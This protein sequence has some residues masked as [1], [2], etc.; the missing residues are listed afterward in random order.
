[1]AKT[2]VFEG[3]PACLGDTG[4][5]QLPMTI[6]QKEFMTGVLQGGAIGAGVATVIDMLIPRI[7]IISGLP[8]TIRPVANAGIAVGIAL[9]VY[10]RNPS[11][12][13]G[14][15]VGGVAVSAY[16]LIAV[17]MGR[18]A[19]VPPAVP[20]RG[21]GQDEI[22]LEGTGESIE[23]EHAGTEGTGV[24]IPVEIDDEMAGAYSYGQEE[25][26]ID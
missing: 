20:A 12:A 3:C 19:A 25:I 26:L 7:P 15:G 5:G 14:I 9:L 21:L 13:V 8:L 16:K 4:Y 1:M 11:L 24:I 6:D 17:L 2:L 10:S 23:I 22:E 18:V